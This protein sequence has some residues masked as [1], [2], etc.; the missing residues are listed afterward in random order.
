[1]NMLKVEK[2]SIAMGYRSKM[3]VYNAIKAGVFTKP[4]KISTGASVWPCNEV[5]I[6]IEARIAGQT[7]EQIRA[8]VD[9]LHTKRTDRFKEC[10][11]AL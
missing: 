4:V 2:V 8:L 6:L 3:S 5:D 11:S 7:K 9:L 1:M 10:L